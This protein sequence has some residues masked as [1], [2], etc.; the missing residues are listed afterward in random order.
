MVYKP[1]NISGGPHLVQLYPHHVLMSPEARFQDYQIYL[2]QT[3]PGEVPLAKSQ[4]KRGRCCPRNPRMMGKP[5]Q[6]TKIQ[7]DWKMGI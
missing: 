2:E 4:R 7:W 1:T 5:L 6:T 3:Y